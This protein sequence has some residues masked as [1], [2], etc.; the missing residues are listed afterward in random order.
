LAREP[1]RVG[2][3]IQGYLERLGFSARLG[4]QAAVLQWSEIAGPKIAEE[5]KALRIDGDTLVVKVN[6]AA[7]R[8]QLT[9]L[10]SELLLRLELKLGKEVIKDIRFI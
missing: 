5:T 4:K 10:K 3:I 2:G 9:F 7:W 8:Q 6:R 1:I